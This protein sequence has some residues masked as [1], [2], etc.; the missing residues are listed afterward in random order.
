MLCST[1]TQATHYMTNR[2]ISN[3]MYTD[4]YFIDDLRD[5]IISIMITM[6]IKDIIM[7]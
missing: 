1:N 4:D 3:I 5:I 2:H 6:I 7:L